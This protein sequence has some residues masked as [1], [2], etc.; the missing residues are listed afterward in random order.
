MDMYAHTGHM[1]KISSAGSDH[2]AGNL[3]DGREFSARVVTYGVIAITVGNTSA[4]ATGELRRMDYDNRTQDLPHEDFLEI[5]ELCN[6]VYDGVPIGQVLR[7]FDLAAVVRGDFPGMF[8]VDE[9]R[10]VDAWEVRPAD[11]DGYVLAYILKVGD[12]YGVTPTIWE[13]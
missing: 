13:G 12:A 7:R 4:I 8:T 6:A 11:G 2:I 9:H 3:E 5:S 10:D 1:T